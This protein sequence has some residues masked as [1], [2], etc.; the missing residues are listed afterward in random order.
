MNTENE[1]LKIEINLLQTKL[2]DLSVNKNSVDFETS[3]LV[4]TIA[5]LEQNKENLEK[6]S[7][8]T[9]TIGR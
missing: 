4:T 8:R 2:D 5:K 6:K 1:Q 3:E 9:S 7:R